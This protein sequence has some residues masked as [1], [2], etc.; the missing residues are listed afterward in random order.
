LIINSTASAGNGS[1]SVNNGG[2]L[3]GNGN[4][5]GTVNV[6]SGG[7]VAPGNSVGAISVGGLTLNGGGL[8]DMEGDGSGFDR[9][10]VTLD[11]AFSIAGPT[12]I[13][14]SDLGGVSAGD[15]VLIDY[16]SAFTGNFSDLSLASTQLGVYTAS[17]VDDG[18]DTSIKLHIS[19]GGN[20]QWDVD[21]DGNWSLAANWNPQIVPDGAA[22][23][24]SFLGKITA[25]RTVTLDGTRT[26]GT[27]AFDN[28]NKYTIAAG[29]GTLNIGDAGTAGSV[30]VTSGSHEIAAPVAING[31]SNLTVATGGGLT[32]SGGVS[33]AAGKT[34]TKAGDGTLTISGAQNHAAGAA[35]LVTR[36]TVN[37]NSNAGVAG[38]AANSHLALTV[39]GNVD[40]ANTTVK[41][42]ANQDLKELS[43]AIADGGTQTLDLASP[44]G[45]GQFR[46]VSVYAADLAGAK[47]SLYIAIANA[48]KAGAADPLD[49]IV[50]SGMHAG[51]NK[52]G[53][54]QSGDHITIRSTRVGDLNLDG[55]VTI[56]DFIDLASNFGSTGGVSTWQ[57]GDLN[58]DRNVTISDFIDLAANFGSSYSGNVVVSAGDVQT[59][60]S[61]ASS[62]GVDPSVVGSAVPEPGML[63]L[64]A[65]GAMGLMGRRRRKA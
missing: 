64:L 7:H 41:L 34:A 26:V 15:Y 59:L 44:A 38:S 46:S 1:V 20:P 8:L 16:S 30:I 61:F 14:L 55:S 3:G 23:G 45:A 13:N 21:G 52:I 32:L 12:T 49:G 57:E 54:A 17:L 29:S 50:D 42:G 53:L 2:A 47:N 56:S 24:A 39:A 22:G 18:A 36:G 62:I 35:L 11:N 37:I 27:L 51:S 65:V 4:I 43:V 10:N 31:N 6:N 28:A 25:P 33:I 9:I 19:A 5:L 58:Y 60:T 48:N 40:N 63:S